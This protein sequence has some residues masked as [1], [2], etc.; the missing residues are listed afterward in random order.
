MQIAD[1]PIKTQTFSGPL[2]KLLE[3][4]ESKEVD[5]SQLG[6]AAVTEDFLFYV[7]NNREDI[8][9]ATLSEFVSIASKLLLLKSKQILP[10]FELSEEEES[11]IEELQARLE[12]YR[13]FRAKSSAAAGEAS[14]H[15]QALYEGSHHCFGRK[16]LSSLSEGVV[17]YPPPGLLAH[18]LQAQMRSLLMKEEQY[19]EPKYTITISA[20]SLQQKI[21][22]IG[23]RLEQALAGGF[24]AVT[25]NQPKHEVIVSFLAILHMFAS[26]LID[27]DQTNHF[28]DIT[29]RKL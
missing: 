27:L 28:E 8:D 10:S 2:A 18:A 16:L 11:S 12:V 25:S 23:Q 17:F 13:L 19:L 5:I 14:A 24:R 21:D 29:I 20:I 6:L 26:R 3:L 1:F 15:L 7:Q 4:I 22:E 9:T